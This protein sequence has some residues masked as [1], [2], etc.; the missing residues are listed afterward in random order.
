MYSLW[1]MQNSPTQ[2][3]SRHPS[4]TRHANRQV[5]RK[6]VDEARRE[7]YRE[8]IID[9]AEAVFAERG[10]AD[11]KMSDIAH[12]AGVALKTLYSAFKGKTELYHRI[13]ELR[14]EEMLA[15]AAEPTGESA[16]DAAMEYVRVTVEYFLEHPNFL[17]THLREGNA[18]AVGPAMKAQTEIGLWQKNMQLAADI[19]RSGIE[20]GL[21]VDEDPA[22]MTKM[23]TA[24]YQVHLADW[25]DRET[26]GDQPEDSAELVA[27][28]QRHVTRL[29]CRVDRG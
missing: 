15:L 23:S 14:C 8:L 1:E 18:W 19:V 24:V 3:P 6:Q 12:A 27:R 5:A 2:T 28:I 10:F 22:L 9:A 20:E 13:H 4:R 29:L 21:F 17:R 11:A 25:L 26:A 7:V 16:L